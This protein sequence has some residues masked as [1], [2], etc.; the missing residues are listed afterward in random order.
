MN[1][2]AIPVLLQAFFCASL[3]QAAITTYPAGP[4]VETI[5]DI[6]HNLHLFITPID[7]GGHGDPDGFDTVEN[8]SF[9]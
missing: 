2:K 8:I 9:E 6:F 4:D 3:L 7:V 1:H 5:D